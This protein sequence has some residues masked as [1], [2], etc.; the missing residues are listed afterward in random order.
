MNTASKMGRWGIAGS[1]VGLL[2]LVA[3]VLP[4]WVLPAIFPPKPIDQVI[5]E[6]AS[7]VKEQLVAAANGSEYQ[8]SVQKNP[9][10]VW[11]QA[12]SIAAVSLGLVAIGLAVISFLR[13][14]NRRYAGAA[15]ALGSGAIAFEFMVMALAVVVAIVIVVAVFNYLGVSP[16]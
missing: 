2:A 16:G 4:L 10:T 3:A 9:A 11:Y 13:Q 8:A 14:E 12:S 15:A 1:I 5:V 6:T 7:K